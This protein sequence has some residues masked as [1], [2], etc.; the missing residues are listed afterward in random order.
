M[1]EPL[2]IRLLAYYYEFPIKIIQKIISL[3]L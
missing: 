3:L 1:L 2:Y